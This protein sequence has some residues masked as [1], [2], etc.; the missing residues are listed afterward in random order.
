MVPARGLRAGP[1]PGAG[2]V[3]PIADRPRPRSPARSPASEAAQSLLPGGIGLAARTLRQMALDQRQL[4]IRRSVPL[5]YHGSSDC[6]AWCSSVSSWITRAITASLPVRP[7]ASA[8]SS[9]APMEHAGLHRVHRAIHDLR[10]LGVGQVVEIRQHQHVALLVR[11][12]GRAPASAPRGFRDRRSAAPG[13]AASLACSSGSPILDRHILPAHRLA[14]RAVGDRED[15]GRKLALAVVGGGPAPDRQHGVVQAF[16]D[17]GARAASA[18]TGSAAGAGGRSDR[19]FRKHAGRP[20]A[21]RSI[22]SRSS[23]SVLRPAARCR[24]GQPGRNRLGRRLRGDGTKH[25]LPDLD[26]SVSSA[27]PAKGSVGAPM[28]AGRYLAAN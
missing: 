23:A 17:D 4:V 22:S 11:K 6:T 20:S 25:G 13:R 12:T 26:C 7:S 28:Q 16:L 14:G 27:A 5:T 19:G 8:R 24:T 9:P 18:A 2:T 15:P 1:V 3:Q 10:D 21:T